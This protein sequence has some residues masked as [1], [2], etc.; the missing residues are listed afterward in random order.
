MPLLS[1]YSLMLFVVDSSTS[2]T[3]LPVSSST[4]VIT[5]YRPL[6]GPVW[7][8][9]AQHMAMS[10][11]IHIHF[12]RVAAIYREPGGGQNPSLAFPLS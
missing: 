10:M 3:P 5:K 4:T 7:A 9:A 12:I 8:Y 11:T 1:V 6:C 2:G